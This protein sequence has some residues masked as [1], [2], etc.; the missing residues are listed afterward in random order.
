MIRERNLH[1]SWQQV[2][3]EKIGVRNSQLAAI[4]VCWWSRKGGEGIEASLE[5]HHLALV[6]RS[7][8]LSCMVSVPGCLQY[9]SSLCQRPG[10]CQA[11]DEGLWSCRLTQNRAKVLISTKAPHLRPSRSLLNTEMLEQVTKRGD[12]T[13]ARSR[14]QILEELGISGGNV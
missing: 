7:H 3:D 12:R 4:C 9:P 1:P 13:A 6:P 11:W 2:F 14:L 10:I 8:G 5:G